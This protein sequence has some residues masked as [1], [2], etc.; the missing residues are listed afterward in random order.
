MSIIPVI[1]L[2]NGVVVH[3]QKGLRHAYREIRSNLTPKTNPEAVLDAYYQLFPFKIIYIADLNAIARKHNHRQTIVR[4]A[5]S[6]PDCQFWVDGGMAYFEHHPFSSIKNICLVLGVE[7]KLSQNDYKQLL[8]Q[9]PELILSLDFN[10]DGLLA[11]SYLLHN[12]AQWS[13]RVIVMMLHRV[14]SGDGVD[15]RCLNPVLEKTIKSD[16]YAAGGIRD[17]NDIQRLAAAGVSGVLLASALHD[18]SIT[19]RDLHKLAQDIKMP[20]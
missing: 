14:G 3:A 16:I 17:I 6:R 11:N 8:E 2:L 15:A 4:L 19:S 12:P 18:G 10:A 9:Y 20:R 13:T 5:Q 1:D 7:N